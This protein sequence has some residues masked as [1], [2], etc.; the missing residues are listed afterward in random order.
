MWHRHPAWGWWAVTAPVRWASWATFSSWAG[1]AYSQPA[2]YDYGTNVV[3]EGDTVYIEGNEVG[4]AEE[5]AQQAIEI[6]NA[7]AE[8][9]AKAEAEQ[10]A[11]ELEWLPLGVHAM[12]SEENE[13]E[14][15][16]LLQLAVTKD[17]TIGGTIY[18]SLTDTTKG[19]QGSVDPTTQRAAI[20]V[21]GKPETVLE[22]GVYNLTMDKAKALIHFGTD[23]TQTWYLE[24]ADEPG[25]EE[26]EN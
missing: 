21:I 15:H 17:G 26:K 8:A 3:Y 12:S 20:S 2:Y 19:V 16:L 6:A 25:E 24:R 13:K 1:P 22:T 9:I 23:R 10:K 11:D 7:G 4:S 18:D 5:F 14:P